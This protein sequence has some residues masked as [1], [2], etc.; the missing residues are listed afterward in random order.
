MVEKGMGRVRLGRFAAVTVPAAIASAGLGLAIVQGMVSATLSSA[1]GFD[2]KTDGLTAT[3]LSVAPGAAQVAGSANGAATALARV[4]DAHLDRMCI[5]VNQAL[6]TS[7]L[8]L[9][10]LGVDVVSSDS[11]V[12]L[13]NVDLN[14]SDLTAGASVLNDTTVG[15]AQSQTDFATGTQ[16]DAY[17]ANG[18]ALTSNDVD[19]DQVDSK[20]YAVTLSGGLALSGLSIKPSLPASSTTPTCNGF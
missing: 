14:A 19:L 9:S 13:D 10:R 1:D 8:G 4:G 16:P 18:F 12:E 20:A 6:P 2:L 15:V 11:D 3:T 7:V 5:G 17:A